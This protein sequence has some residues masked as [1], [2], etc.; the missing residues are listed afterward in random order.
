M[1]AGLSWWSALPT[2]REAP[3]REQVTIIVND[4]IDGDKRTMSTVPASDTTPGT[5]P[6]RTPTKMASNQ[7]L[8]HLLN[9][10]LPPRQTHA[11]QSLPR[12]SRKTGNQHGIWNKESEWSFSPLIDV[13]LK[14]MRRQSSSMPSTGLS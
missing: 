6:K 9:F 12:R 14:G 3:H 7:S 1:R 10:T 11:L 2:H 5:T 8:N 4:A 13:S